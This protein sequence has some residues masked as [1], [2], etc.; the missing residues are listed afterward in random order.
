MFEKAF[1]HF[2]FSIEQQ[3]DIVKRKIAA[4]I[5]GLGCITYQI[6]EPW[7]SLV[8][9]QALPPSLLW[10][11][12]MKELQKY[13]KA[14]RCSDITLCSFQIY[15]KWG[16]SLITTGRGDA[17]G[18]Q[19]LELLLSVKT[20]SSNLYNPIGFDFGTVFPSLLIKVLWFRNQ[21]RPGIPH[22]AH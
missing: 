8:V 21:D 2:E 6:S 12:N 10:F 18:C 22:T 9:P 3:T 15:Q 7:R 17:V 5:N 20:R 16:H 14:Y 4:K 13:N 11:L 1:N 19:I